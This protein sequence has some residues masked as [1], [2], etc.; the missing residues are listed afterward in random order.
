MRTDVYFRNWV[1]KRK[2]VAEKKR[3]KKAREQEKKRKE[4]LVAQGKEAEAEEGA[5]KGP[6]FFPL[7]EHS[8]S[9]DEERKAEIIQHVTSF[10]SSDRQQSLRRKS[11]I[12]PR[13]LSFIFV[14]FS[15]KK[16]Y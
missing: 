12:S 13:S 10:V 9:S 1:K 7:E 4:A 5:D 14:Q 3:R 16:R 2:M 15:K 8:S 11:I 6:S